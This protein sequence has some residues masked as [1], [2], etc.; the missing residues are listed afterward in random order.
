MSFGKAF[1][2]S[3][4][5]ALIAIVIFSLFFFMI[6]VGGFISGMNDSDVQVKKN[7]FLL[8]DPGVEIVENHTPG[9]FDPSELLS[10]GEQS[11]M[12]LYQIVES[13][14][15]AKEDDK[16]KGIYI[17]PKTGV[18]G[19]GWAGKKAIRDALVDFKESGKPVYAYSELYTEGFYYVASAADHLYMYPE[20]WMEFNG[21]VSDRMYMKN[22]F[23]KLEV[24]PKIFRVGKYKSAVEPYFRED[25]SEES[26]EQTAAFLGD[27]WKVFVKEVAASRDIP[28]ETMDKLAESF[29]LGYGKDAATSGLVDGVKYEDQVLAEIKETLE[30][31]EDAE[32]PFVSLK[33]YIKAGK[34]KSKGGKKK[35][36]IVF[37]EGAIQSGKS[38]DGVIGS[39]TV[40]KAL[41]KAREDSDVKAIVFRVN[42]PGG[43]ALAS[44]VIAREIEL[45]KK[46]K[47]VIASMGDLAASGGYYISAK[48]DKIF[49]EENTITG[50]IGI[51]GVLFNTKD[52]FNNK[53]GLTFD[54][55]ETHSH[56]NFGN[57]NYPMDGV[58][59][60]VFQTLI[61]GGYE[62]FLTIVQHG[63]DFNTRDEVNEI[64]Q[65]RVWS[66]LHAKDINLVD[67]YGGLDDAIAAAAAEAG[68]GD[69]YDVR[70]LPK[71][72]NPIME[73]LGQDE[74]VK[75][76]IRNQ[77]IPEEMQLLLDLKKQ[78]PSS[79][80]YM[81]LP[82]Q[83][84][85]K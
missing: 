12:G 64:A 45:C 85:V 5:G 38:G 63:R 44:D 21:F 73:L 27:M 69:D 70:L 61:N 9:Q 30:L 8:F 53:L 67:E 57:P 72:K 19:G 71:Q 34:G 56:A 28:V 80:A 40:V 22:M 46:E 23:E 66:G 48:C 16:I 4:M 78:I 79:G 42:S 33:K 52:L 77:Y 15:R 55:V 11:K 41:R 51:F 76:Y 58:E 47:P 20:G 25:M 26:R 75:A 3:L 35:I 29:I 59:D 36:A 74:E 24:E 84:E 17:F 37:A 13:I 54:D 83:V 6:F 14:K 49:A 10:G 50:S 7:S 62:Q 60:T 1:L 65:G 39:T 18:I 81:M 43:S 31:E 32:I 82:Y 2:A 68:L